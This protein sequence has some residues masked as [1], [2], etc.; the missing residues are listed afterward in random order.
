[1][2]EGTSWK[3]DFKGQDMKL[4]KLWP[5]LVGKEREE[6]A[7]GPFN[8]EGTLS[9]GGAPSGKGGMW[10]TFNGQGELSGTDVTFQNSSFFR[11]ILF[12][13]AGPVGT[14]FNIVTLRDRTLDANS[15]FFNTAKGTYIITNGT[16]RTEDLYFDGASV[17]FYLKGDINFVENNYD[18]KAVAVP[19]AT[20]GTLMG[21]VPIIGK[22]MAKAK[23]SVLSYKFK[24]TGPLNEPEAEL[25]KTEQV[26]IEE[27]NQ[28][29]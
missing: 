28:E 1:M 17:D 14:L 9:G 6:K 18:M 16:A 25:T 29:P 12:A 5:Q 22:G 27:K 20:V 15:L 23:R 4:E 8:A 10:E 21:M 13:A 3:T 24:I 19:L 11:S 7:K 2:K 26:E